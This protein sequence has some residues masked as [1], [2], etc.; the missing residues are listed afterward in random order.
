[1]ITLEEFKSNPFKRIHDS[2]AQSFLHMTPSVE[3]ANGEVLLASGYRAL[4]AEAISEKNTP[5]SGKKFLR[6]VEAGRRPRDGTNISAADWKSVIQDTLRSPKQP[7]QSKQ[8]FLQM[9][10]LVPDVALYCLSAR[11][12]GNPWNP[13][14]LLKKLVHFGT[15]SIEEAECF[16][17][18][19]FDSLKVDEYD[20]PWARFLDVEFRSWRQSEDK[21][22]F[23]NA[24]QLARDEVVERFRPGSGQSPAKQFCNDLSALISVK[25]MLTRRQWI[26]LLESLIRLGAASHVMW[27]AEQNKQAAKLLYAAMQGNPWSNIEAS[28]YRQRPFLKIDQYVSSKRKSAAIE[29]SQ[30]KSAAIESEKARLQINLLLLHCGEKFGEDVTNECLASFEHINQFARKIE[31]QFTETEKKALIGNLQELL[32]SDTRRFQCKSGRT[33]NIVE[34]LQHTLQQRRTSERGLEPYD[35]GFYIKKRGVHNNAKW[36][37]ALGPVAVIA[38][39]HSCTKNLAGKANMDDLLDHLGRYGIDL[40]QDNRE[41]SSL[42]ATLRGLGLVLDSP[43]AEGGMALVEPLEDNSLTE[44]R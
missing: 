30:L 7:K 5:S 2:Y 10:P 35:Q 25:T 4:S 31:G 40:S 32:E 43:D 44:N 21:D 11:L 6:R 39:V 9:S 37:V 29:S 33:K 42:V 12:K 26:S 23:E 36:E 41:D 19:L 28:S 15:D 27:V 1:M 20:D 16:W 14:E 22:F 18:M 3:Y 17:S 34:F 38:L 24:S 8:H 13:R